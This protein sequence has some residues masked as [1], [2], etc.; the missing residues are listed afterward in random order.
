MKILYYDCFSGISGDMNLGAMIDLGV[1]SSLL[2]EELNK[3]NLPGWQL[4]TGKDQRHG[5]HGT[6]V[7]VKLTRHEHHH[8]H[9]SDIE[10]IINDSGLDKKTKDLS[11]RIF[12]KVAEAEAFVHKVPVE[13]VHF[14]EVGAVDS[15][16]D[17]VGAAICFN[18]LEVD[19]VH[20]SGVE[21][22]S[23]FVKCAHGTLPVPA[24]ATAEIIKGIPVKTG[25]VDFEATTPTGAAIVA[26][27]GKKFGPLTGIRIEKTG[28]GV[29]QKDHPDVP[30]LLRVFIGETEK[31]ETG[32]D[33]LLIECNIDDMIPEFFDNIAEKLKEAGVSDVYITNIIMKKGRPG[34]L[35]SVICE[36]GKEDAV[37]EIIFRESTT[38]GLRTIPFR[39]ETLERKFEPV[40]TLYGTVTVKRSYF[41][42]RQVSVK[43]E[44]DDC[45]RI[46]REYD[47]PLKEVYNKIMAAIV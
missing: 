9:L 15:I 6:K 7:T 18:A 40:E 23:G 33:A 22:G 3:L 29:G 11:L 28:Y 25:G 46:A 47:L 16:V 4:I 21:L 37:K 30:N 20:V 45:K 5:I 27:L 24:P 26:T 2:E 8:R 17:I 34:N 41:N 38:V 44:Y 12:R 36:K 32:H 39:K 14:H 43:P 42:G 31:T 13:R 10:T 19:E 35:L 1:S